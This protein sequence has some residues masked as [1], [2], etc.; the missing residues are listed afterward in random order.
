M[1]QASRQAGTGGGN[2]A[3]KCSESS[4]RGDVFSVA[5]PC[6]LGGLET[7]PGTQDEGGEEDISTPQ[8]DRRS[9]A[10]DVPGPLPPFALHR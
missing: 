9:S 8:S 2:R 5:K 10:A 6:S 1:E 4:H 7:Q 3:S